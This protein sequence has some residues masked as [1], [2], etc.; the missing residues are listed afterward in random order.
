MRLISCVYGAGFGAGP[1]GH[2]S[3]TFAWYPRLGIVQGSFLRW[4]RF[5]A[6]AGERRRAVLLGLNRYRQY[7]VGANGFASCKADWRRFDRLAGRA[8]RLRSE[9]TSVQGVAQGIGADGGLL[10]AHNGEVREYHAGE[11]S[12]RPASS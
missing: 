12:V 11:V 3:G 2:Y 5:R 9:S 8:L 4:V 10:V 7:G 1:F 6:G